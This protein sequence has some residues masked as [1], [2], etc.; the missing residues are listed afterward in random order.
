MRGGVDHRG[1]DTYHRMPEQPSAEYDDFHRRMGGE[2]DGHVRA[3]R[4]DGGPQRW[5]EMPRD[6]NRRGA[7]VEDNHLAGLN[8]RSAE[9]AERYLLLR[10][11]LFTRLQISHGRRGR[12]GAAVDALQLT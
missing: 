10:R 3:V 4:D 2:F 12:Q 9:A 5:V 6:L 8:E 11:H 7:A 1:A